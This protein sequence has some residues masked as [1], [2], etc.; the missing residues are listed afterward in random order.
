ME[1]LGPFCLH[2]K[3]H[4]IVLGGHLETERVDLN[5]DVCP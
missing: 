2:N 4:I 1:T 5:L 3:M